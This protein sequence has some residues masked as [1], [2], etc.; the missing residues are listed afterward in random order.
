MVDT[1]R[2]ALGRNQTPRAGQVS[3]DLYHH[4]G[5]LLAGIAHNR[6]RDVERIGSRHG[7]EPE[8]VFLFRLCCGGRDDALLDFQGAQE[9]IKQAAAPEQFGAH[10]N[11]AGHAAGADK[12]AEM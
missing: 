6:L 3:E 12:R 5:Q 11:R 7:V 4:A 9:L 8:A 2:L 10:T 1:R